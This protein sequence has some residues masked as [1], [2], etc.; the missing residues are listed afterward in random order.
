MLFH[1]VRV[2]FSWPSN[3]KK[4]LGA[5]YFLD[6]SLPGEAAAT[7]RVVDDPEQWAAAWRAASWRRGVT[8]LEAA[9]F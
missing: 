2:L 5:R 4:C 8:G 1:F 9:P 6:V 7:C 3:K